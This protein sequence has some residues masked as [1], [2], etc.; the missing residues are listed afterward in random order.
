MLRND[1]RKQGAYTPIVEL[2]MIGNKTDKLSE[3]DIW[4]GEPCSA[5]APVRNAGASDA[6]ACNQTVMSG[7]ITAA[8]VD[9]LALFVEFDHVRR[10]SC[11]LFLVRNWC[12][13]S[14]IEIW[15]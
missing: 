11:G 10:A 5:R 1:E 12:G 15:T 14:A 2:D 4:C 8:A 9:F 3:E 13:S 6:R 7:G